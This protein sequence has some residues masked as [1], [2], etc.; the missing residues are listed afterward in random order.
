[1]CKCE[2]KLKRLCKREKDKFLRSLNRAVSVTLE[3]R[4]KCMPL[5]RSPEIS[6]KSQVQAYLTRIIGNP[7]H[8]IY[9]ATHSLLEIIFFDLWCITQCCNY[10]LPLWF[11]GITVSNNN[12]NHHH[13]G[14]WEKRV[15]KKTENY[16][17]ILSLLVF[18]VR[19]KIIKNPITYYFFWMNL[20]VCVCLFVCSLATDSAKWYTFLT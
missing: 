18:R 8:L 2:S 11:N 19:I 3:P 7:L 13:R 17:D 9:R 4:Q 6:G 14:V 15:I 10:V 20:Y 12:K 5:S 1:M 16:F